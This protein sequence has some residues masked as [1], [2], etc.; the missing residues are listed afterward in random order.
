VLAG[1]VLCMAIAG[2]VYGYHR[3]RVNAAPAASSEYQMQNEP[4]VNDL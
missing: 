1:I 3:R 4:N 2:V